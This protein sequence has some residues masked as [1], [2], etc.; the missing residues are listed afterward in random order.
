MPQAP[1][2]AAAHTNSSSSSTEAAPASTSFNP[3]PA[4]YGD[5]LTPETI[6][7][8]SEMWKNPEQLKQAR[9]IFVPERNSLRG[10]ARRR[11]TLLFS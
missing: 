1:K 4:A 7:A 9:R 8:A 3:V 10:A 2:Y 11:C 5:M 6:K